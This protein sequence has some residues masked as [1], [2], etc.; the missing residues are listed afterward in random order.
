MQPTATATTTALAEIEVFDLRNAAFA[1]PSLPLVIGETLAKGS[2]GSVAE[3]RYRG[4]PGWVV[5]TEVF[6]KHGDQLANQEIAALTDMRGVRGFP[7]LRAVVRRDDRVQLVI[8]QLPVTLAR[9]THIAPLPREDV[10]RVAVQV[11]D[12]LEALHDKGWLHRDIK[13]E[14]LMLDEQSATVYLIDFGLAKKFVRDGVHVTDV[15]RSGLLGT[16]RYCS[17]PVHK[18]HTHSRRDDLESLLYTL[19]F[20]EDGHL[21]W[22]GA[23]FRRDRNYEAHLNK[24]LQVGGSIFWGAKRALYDHVRH[25]AFTQRPDYAFLREAFLKEIPGSS[26]TKLTRFRFTSR[27]LEEGRPTRNALEDIRAVARFAIRGIRATPKIRARVL[28]NLTAEHRSNWAL[29]AHC[30]SEASVSLAASTVNEETKKPAPPV[31]EK[32]RPD[33][34]NGLFQ[35]VGVQN[36]VCDTS[37]IFRVNAPLPWTSMGEQSHTAVFALTNLARVAWTYSRTGQSGLTSLCAVS[38]LDGNCR[39]YRFEPQGPLAAVPWRSI[40]VAASG[41]VVRVSDSQLDLVSYASGPLTVQVG[42]PVSLTGT[43]QVHRLVSETVRIE[44]P[45]LIT[46][47]ALKVVICHGKSNGVRWFGGWQIL[48]IETSRLKLVH[49]F[50]IS[51]SAAPLGIVYSS[52]RNTVVAWLPDR[53]IFHRVASDSSSPYDDVDVIFAGCKG[54]FEWGSHW[55]LYNTAELAFLDAESLEPLYLRYIR[56]SDPLLGVAINNE[57][58]LVAHKFSGHIVE[59]EDLVRFTSARIELDNQYEQ[60]ILDAPR[61]LLV[62]PHTNGNANAMPRERIAVVSLQV[63]LPPIATA[64]DSESN[65]AKRHVSVINSEEEDEAS[66][67]LPEKRLHV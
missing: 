53:V 52:T 45:W 26:R 38:L 61:C 21:P 67:D 48:A 11:I 8:Q 27:K 19:Q 64:A 9:L 58:I 32:K 7:T 25:L 42:S 22:A 1:A 63:E 3:A 35:S 12:A 37:V 5:K 31:E 39:Y 65:T 66:I 16:P 36:I 44:E 57:A 4:E 20:I 6:Q 47:D 51:Y 60:I 49:H 43:C 34:D 29:L 33:K 13:P 28:R 55:L 30:D 62:S 23:G 40:Y 2:F 15:T 17:I 59:G 41:C 14:N 56:F 24:K 46:N 50:S 10:A 54:V 18:N